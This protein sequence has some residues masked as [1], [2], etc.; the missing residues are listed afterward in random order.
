MAP[1]HSKFAT[2]EEN[3][4]LNAIRALSAPEK[5]RSS[6]L[7]KEFRR[8]RRNVLEGFLNCVMSTVAAM[9]AIGQGLNCFCPPILVA[10]DDLARM[11]VIAMLLD[12]LLQK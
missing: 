11:Q 7:T 6:Y 3:R 8:A 5:V 2:T 9:S 4:F 1:N 10:G 12:G